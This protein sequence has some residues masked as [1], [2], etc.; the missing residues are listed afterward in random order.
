MAIGDNSYTV[1]IN[2]SEF[3]REGWKRGRYKGTKLT[4]YDQIALLNL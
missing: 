1:E 3:E 2:D 4:K